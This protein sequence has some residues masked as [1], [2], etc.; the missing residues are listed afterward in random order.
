M[1]TALLLVPQTTALKNKLH[2]RDDQKGYLLFCIL[3]TNFLFIIGRC[4]SHADS[5]R[6][7]L[8]LLRQIFT[9]FQLFSF[10]PEALFSFGLTGGM[11]VQVGLF[12]VVMLLVGVKQERGI[13]M[14]S[15]LTEQ[16]WY[17]Q[18]ILMVV[19]LLVLMLLVYGN[20]NYVPIDYVYEGI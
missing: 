3:R 18:F 5:L 7:A 15:Y 12:L 13:D 19:C 9:R 1:S 8:S 16:K 17:I 14:R 4:F 10:N 20:N 11:Y 6:Q 2:I